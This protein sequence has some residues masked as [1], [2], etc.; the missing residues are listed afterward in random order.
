[1]NFVQLVN[2][3]I[4]DAFGPSLAAFRPELIL[5]ATI[6]GLL[7]VRM[8]SPAD[9]L[10]AAVVAL[11]G[12]IAAL[13]FAAPW[14]LAGD[15]LAKPAELFNGLITADPMAIYS[16]SLILFFL[17]LFIVFTWLSKIPN[18]DDAA[19]F[20]VLVFG[21]VI[22]MCLM[23]TA[24]HILIAFL[25]MEMASVPSYA[26]AGFLRDRRSAG[27][28]ALKFAVFG[29]GAAG[30]FLYG[31][32][33]LAGV[34]GSAH[35]PTMAEKLALVL[36]ENAGG[37]RAIVLA[38]A[39]LAML[40]GLSF[41]LS[42]VPFHFWAPD[43]FEGAA[44]EIGAFLSVASK[45]AAMVLLLRLGLALT[46]TPDA[47]ANYHLGFARMYVGGLIALLAAVTCTF[48]N[49]A[50]Y[51]QTN[52]KRLLAYSTIAHAGYMMLG[53]AAAIMLA[54]GNRDASQTAIAG[55]LFYLGIYLFMNLGAFAC[56]AFF[57]NASGSE[58]INSYAGLIR[59]SPGFALCF[60][61]VLMS[62]FGLPPLAGFAG[63][64]AIFL[65]LAVKDVRLLTLLA[66][67]VLNTVLSLFYYLRVVRAMTVEP[68]S[69]DQ[70]AATVPMRSGVGLYTL[71]VVLPIVVL[72]V[73]WNLL[74]SLAA[75]AASTLGGP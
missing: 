26:L 38:F 4:S 41:K 60:A 11:A 65:S 56:A 17:A 53:A 73:W 58:E 47:T 28:A 34:L 3:A 63:K 52:I 1:M 31:I 55:V 36:Q 49:L 43:V 20:F 75:A 10:H 68:E 44:A 21:A 64:F 15:S 45:A 71:A 37:D 50:A 18:R 67:G 7:L 19:E 24:N 72:G 25:G 35:L 70:P 62:L 8:F 2:T 32:S 40:V 29:A 51:G 13:Y 27:E 14:R 74:Y 39:G 22:G 57:R 6:V 61:I 5:C 59:R 30:I 48:G 66:V 42:A 69:T 23:C 33:L 46:T 16:R 54:G 12:S 9:K